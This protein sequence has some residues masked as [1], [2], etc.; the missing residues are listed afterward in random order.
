MA[1]PR[2]DLPVTD[3][4]LPA[5]ALML[6][7]EG[8]VPFVAPKTWRDTFRRLILLEDGQVRFLGLTAMVL[9]VILLTFFH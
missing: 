6:I 4:L 1:K 7:L 5:L 8:I 3:L 2:S 9:G